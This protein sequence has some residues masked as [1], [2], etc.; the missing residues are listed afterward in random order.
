MSEK[1]IM[2][3]SNSKKSKKAQKTQ[4]N[5]IIEKFYKLLVSF[6]KILTDWKNC[7]LSGNPVIT[8]D[9]L[10]RKKDQFSTGNNSSALWNFLC[11]S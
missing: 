1:S 9:I 3:S 7:S 8:E 10:S 4:P 11:P 6:D 5:P 2:N